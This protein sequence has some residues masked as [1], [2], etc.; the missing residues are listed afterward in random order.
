M[1]ELQIDRTET[2]DTLGMIALAEAVGFD[3]LEFTP[4]V[5][6]MLLASPLRLEHGAV[7]LAVGN[8]E[9]RI[10][11]ESACDIADDGAACLR[12]AVFIV[13]P[14]AAPDVELPFPIFEKVR[15]HASQ[16]SHVCLFYRN[17]DGRELLDV[18]RAH[19]W[20]GVEWYSRSAGTVHRE[21]LLFSAGW[22]RHVSLHVAN[23]LE[24]YARELTDG[25][26]LSISLIT[27]LER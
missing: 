14:E 27:P 20:G 10:V 1:A 17:R 23:G 19:I 21:G 2:I 6:E 12:E 11:F 3:D 4:L 18:F 8:G 13:L 25:T 15:K 22:D 5:R 16:R 26:G 9:K 24:K 7:T